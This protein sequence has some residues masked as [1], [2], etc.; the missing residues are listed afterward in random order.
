MCA[1]LREENACDVTRIDQS[2]W[3]KIC[4]VTVTC[5]KP[6][7]IDLETALITN[8]ATIVRIS[9]ASRHALLF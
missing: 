9:Y 1:R 7:T 6:K 3:L 4:D 5:Q 8:V 2:D